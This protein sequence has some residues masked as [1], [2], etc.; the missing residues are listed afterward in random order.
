LQLALVFKLLEWAL[1]SGNEPGRV[2]E[3]TIE[4][5]ACFVKDYA[6]PMARKTA[7]GLAMTADERVAIKVV[8]YIMDIS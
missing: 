6:E 7:R 3:G 1:T 2:D 5:A 8:D 4:K